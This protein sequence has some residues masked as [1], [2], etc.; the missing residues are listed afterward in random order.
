MAEIRAEPADFAKRFTG[1]G[2]LSSDFIGCQSVI[3]SFPRLASKNR[4][5]KVKK[6]S[7]DTCNLYRKGVQLAIVT[8]MFIGTS[9]ILVEENPKLREDFL[10]PKLQRETLYMTAPRVI[11]L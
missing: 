5:K 6:A 2:H 11:R 4:A 9:G 3:C 1:D 8:R 7:L 10:S